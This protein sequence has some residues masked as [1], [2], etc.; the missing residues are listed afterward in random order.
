MKPRYIEEND[1]KRWILPNGVLHREDGP[2][3][4]YSGGGKWWYLNGQLHRENGPAIEWSNGDKWWYLNGIN[5]TEQEYKIE[6]RSRK[7]KLLL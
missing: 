7:L 1:T 3:C 6:M 5:Y 2:A 4:E